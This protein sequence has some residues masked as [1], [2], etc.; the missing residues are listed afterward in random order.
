MGGMT[1]PTADESVVSAEWI[2]CVYSV[3]LR[4]YMCVCV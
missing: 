2:I 1:G 3:V 4:V